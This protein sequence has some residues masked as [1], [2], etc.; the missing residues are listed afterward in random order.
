MRFSMAVR[1]DTQCYTGYRISI[2]QALIIWLCNA[3]AYPNLACLWLYAVRD[4][5]GKPK[6]GTT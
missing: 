2:G 5:D 4:A 6:K 1:L 3:L